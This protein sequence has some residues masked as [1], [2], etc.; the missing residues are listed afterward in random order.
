M[1]NPVTI[2]A[3]STNR[4][5]FKETQSLQFLENFNIYQFLSIQMSKEPNS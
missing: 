5:T 3:K 1:C 2:E 4:I